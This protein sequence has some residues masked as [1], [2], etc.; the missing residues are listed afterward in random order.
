M[1]KTPTK[2]AKARDYN[3]GSVDRALVVLEAFLAAPE[4][5]LSLA[6]LTRLTGIHK[7]SLLRIC[8][9]LMRRDFLR[10]DD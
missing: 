9:S 2:Q 6:D 3:V 7:T 10:R 8:S 5:A 1:Q 4:A